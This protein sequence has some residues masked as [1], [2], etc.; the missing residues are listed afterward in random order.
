M[1][2][3]A[4]A[5]VASRAVAQYVAE[6]ALPPQPSRQPG[7]GRRAGSAP[8]NNERGRA[9]HPFATHILAEAI[10]PG[11]KIP[12]ISEYDG[13]EDPQD[14]LDRFLAKADLLDISDAAYCKIFRTTLAGKAMVWFN[15][16]L[17]RTIESFEQLSLRFLHYF[18]IN[19]RSEDGLIL[20]HRDSAR[21]REPARLCA[22]DHNPI[23]KKSRRGGGYSRRHVSDNNQK[24]RRHVPPPDVTQYTPLK[25]PHAEILA[26]AERQG[27]VRRPLRMREDPKRMRSS[28]YC[29]FHKDRGH[30]TEDCFHLKDEIEQLIQQGYLEEYIKSDNPPRE[31]SMRPPR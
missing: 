19:K 9:G 16:L 6:H 22:E 28:K 7:R 20:V 1:I 21:A 29:Q 3:D 11:I 18:A 10:Q 31:G 4:S 30:S 26:V 5:Q 13:T 17:I 25:A 15:Q 14:H 24:E 2:E 27:I 8:E 12:N 23:K